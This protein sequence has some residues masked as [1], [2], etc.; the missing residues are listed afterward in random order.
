VGEAVFLAKMLGTQA[1]DAGF[2]ATT[3]EVTGLY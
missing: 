1:G 3:S 2:G